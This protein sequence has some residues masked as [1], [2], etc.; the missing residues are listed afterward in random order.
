MH[1]IISNRNI[2][3][4]AGDTSSSDEKI[5]VNMKNSKGK[6]KKITADNEN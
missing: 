6:L 1:R 2:V 3:K 4:L 5:G